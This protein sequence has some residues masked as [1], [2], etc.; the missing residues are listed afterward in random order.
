LS[1]L[2]ILVIVGRPNVGKSTLFNRLTHSRRAIVGDQPG[3]TR[4]RIKLEG[5]WNGRRF[6]VT[7][8][9]GMTFGDEGEFPQLINERVRQAVDE[10]SHIIFVVDARTELTS[11]DRELAD[12][13]R[14]TGCPV[15]IAANKCDTDRGE[16]MA[17]AFYELKFGEPVPVSAEHNRG[18]ETLFERAATEF[19]L[20]ED[21]EEPG[22][23]LIKV[24]IIGRPNVGKSTLLNR[25]TGEEHSIVSPTP[26]TTRDAV[27]ATIQRDGV[28]FEFVDT[29]GIRRKGK[30]KELAETLSVMMAQRHVRMAHVAIMMLDAVEGVTALDANIAGYAHEAGRAVILV[31]NKWDLLTGVEQGKFERDVRDNLKY[32]DYA[33]IAIISAL[34]GYKTNSLYPLV[35]K[36]YREWKKRITTSELNR[37]LE[38]VDFGRVTVPGFKKPKVSFVTQAQVAPPTFVFFTNRPEPFHFG[39]ERFLINQLRKTFKFYGAPITIRNR[40]KKKRTL[41]ERLN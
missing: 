26:G 1:T 32:L 16:E 7:D 14:R 12:Y 6:L 39:F 33:P 22:E 31:V 19:P 20:I 23:R 40:A 30:T 15:T 35:R 37:F 5:K 28:R 34:E 13:L 41:K 27:D 10:A 2:P 4:D 24:A 3:I 8:T 21:E 18:V 9:G 17:S 29:A 36:V 38:T 11:E 25:L